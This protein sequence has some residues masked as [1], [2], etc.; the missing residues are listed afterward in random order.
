[1]TLPPK[2]YYSIIEVAEEWGCTEKDILRHAEFGKIRLHVSIDDKFKP[3]PL[4]EFGSEPVIVR[5]TGYYPLHITDIKTLIHN[6]NSEEITISHIVF[7]TPEKN[8]QIS[9]EINFNGSLKAQRRHPEFCRSCF[10]PFFES[11]LKKGINFLYISIEDKKEFESKFIPGKLAVKK[12]VNVKTKKDMMDIEIDR[13][14]SEKGDI[15]P[16]LLWAELKSRCGIN[17]NCC[18]R[19][20]EANGEEPEKIRWQGAGQNLSSMSFKNLKDRLY[21]RP[22]RPMST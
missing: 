2:E 3:H 5:A 20:E 12:D 16:G 11:G 13:I 10:V 8:N 9:F 17:G 6:G 14:Y 1:M 7:I 21:R 15:H 19:V 22:K 4:G 18:L